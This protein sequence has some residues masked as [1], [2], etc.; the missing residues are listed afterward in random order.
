MGGESGEIWDLVLTTDSP[1]YDN[2]TDKFDDD[3]I[4]G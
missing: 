1:K 4:E 2:A 3:Y